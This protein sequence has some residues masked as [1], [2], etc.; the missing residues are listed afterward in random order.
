MSKWIGFVIAAVFGLIVGV[1]SLASPPTEFVAETQDSMITAA[2][3][4]NKVNESNAE[5]VNQQTVVNGW[6]ARDLLMISVRQNATLINSTTAAL[7]MQQRTNTLLQGAMVLLVLFLGS[8]AAI[9]MWVVRIATRQAQQTQ[10]Q[11]LSSGS[12]VSAGADSQGD[13]N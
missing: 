5:N 9:G 10:A 1:V 4:D 8:I 3:A 7:E 6:V 11:A 12:D 2:L 13:K